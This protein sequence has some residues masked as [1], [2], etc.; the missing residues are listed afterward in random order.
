MP[1]G[2]VGAP[3]PPAVLPMGKA[4]APPAAAGVKV[5]ALPVILLREAMNPGPLTILLRKV[6]M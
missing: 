4:P 3:A 5:T 1:G 2:P 6:R